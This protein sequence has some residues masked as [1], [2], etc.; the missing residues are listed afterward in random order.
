LLGLEL[1]EA[2]RLMQA[3]RVNFTLPEFEEETLESMLW[4]AE[5]EH[6]QFQAVA[7]LMEAEA[8][9]GRGG[10]NTL[11]EVDE[12]I[13]QFI[14]LDVYEQGRRNF[15][16]L[17]KQHESLNVDQLRRAIHE[18]DLHLHTRDELHALEE[19]RFWSDYLEHSSEEDVQILEKLRL[20]IHDES[21]ADMMVR[22]LMFSLRAAL[23]RRPECPPEVAM[24]FADAIM[25]RIY[26]E[27]DPKGV[28]R[29][30]SEGR[31]LFGQLS[32]Q[33]VQARAFVQRFYTSALPPL[34]VAGLLVGL[35][36]SDPEQRE[37]AR[38]LVAN[39]PDDGLLALLQWSS[40]EDF[41]RLRP[42]YVALARGAGRRI[43]RLIPDVERARVEL[44]VPLI[45]TLRVVG[46]DRFV[47][48]RAQLVRH[49]SLAVR[50]AA[51]EWYLDGDLAEDDLPLI[52][53]AL[54]G[55]LS[56]MRRIALDILKAKR[57]RAARERLMRAFEP[58]RFASLNSEQRFALCRALA[59]VAGDRALPT[60]KQILMTKLPFLVLEGDPAL[61]P[62]E[63]AARGI[64]AIGTP[65]SWAFLEREASGWPSARKQVC[66]R[67]LREER[68]S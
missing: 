49:R 14:E 35:D 13:Q 53:N 67:V 38:T 24:G 7:A 59:H 16:D 2:E 43:L 32:E 58:E 51:M 19:D 63:A 1:S 57:P 68:G 20:E 30:L 50:E 40:A 17:A 45:R 55:R 44:L 52:L 39:M 6:V 62:L 3:L 31:R 15:V 61:E 42:F 65:T 27:G 41:E 8:I 18:R 11:D 66:Q 33:D 37:A 46:G 5:L 56:S 25:E 12:Q 34:R 29:V 47:N 48:I 10:T 64:A 22:T 9:S 23:A 26:A 21:D 54:M 28:T 36:F 4:Q 60:F